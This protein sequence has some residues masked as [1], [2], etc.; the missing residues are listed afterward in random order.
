MF[1]VIIG[2]LEILFAGDYTGIMASAGFEE[3]SALV[4]VLFTVRE[5]F[6]A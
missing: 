2:S 5:W 3:D 1:D 4:N 6:T